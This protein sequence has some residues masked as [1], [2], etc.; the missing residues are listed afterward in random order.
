MTH[1]VAFH[2]GDIPIRWY[3][4]SHICNFVV[5]YLLVRWQFLRAGGRERDTDIMLVATVIATI[6]GGR[7]G[8]V[9]F[10]EWDR[11]VADPTLL[12]RF[13][14]GGI[15][16]HGSTLAFILMIALFSKWRGVRF[17]DVADRMSFGGAF[18]AGIIRLGNL[19]NSEIVGRPT[20]GTWGFRFPR[21]DGLETEILR[22]PSQIYE[23]VM[24]MG[25]LATLLAV[26]RKMGERRPVGLIWTLFLALYFSG[27][28]TV[29]FFK[30][31]QALAA[32][33][34]TMGQWLSLPLATIGWVGVGLALK[35]G[36]PPEPWPKIEE[37][38]S[39]G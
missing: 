12:V 11:F 27:R 25:V 22:H 14:E 7:F 32:G 20:D 37:E 3:S 18:G 23:F 36:R 9:I 2:I 5:G 8:H 28:F 1:P 34:L 39:D 19:A 4:L 31:F 26:D 16:S 29:E 30:E 21:H 10:Y 33:G 35:Y 6:V 24:G 13:G 17:L 38:E 15:A